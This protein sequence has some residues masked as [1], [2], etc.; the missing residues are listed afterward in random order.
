M[1]RRLYV[2]IDLGITSRHEAA[3]YDP[4]TR[5]FVVKSHKFTQGIR[6]YRS[7]MK[8]IKNIADKNTEII[9]CTEPTSTS[10][11]P[12]C[13][14]LVAKRYRVYRV[15][16]QKASDLRKF[17]KRHHKSNNIDA[18]TLAKIA[19]VDDD[20]YPVY[21]P[22]MDIFSLQR[23]CREMDRIECDIS[24]I[25]NRLHT[26]VHFA[27]PELLCCFGKN[28]FTR[29]AR[30]VCRKYIDPHKIVSLGVKRLATF[31]ENHAHGEVDNNLAQK[32]YESALSAIAIYQDAETN[33]MMPV[34]YEVIK[35]ELNMEMDRLEYNEKM[36]KKAQEKV[37]SLYKELDPYGIL[38]TEPGFGDRVA[39]VVLAFGGDVDRFGNIRKFKSFNGNVPRTKASGN[40]EKKGLPI[41]GAGCNMLKKYLHMA[42][43]SGRRWD[44]E[45]ARFHN[46]LIH[47]GLHHNQAV[48]ALA[49]RKA[50]VAYT[51]LKRKKA[52]ERGEITL[53]EAIYQFR[54][55]NGIDIPKEMAR[56]LVLQKF[57]SKRKKKERAI[58]LNQ[59]SLSHQKRDNSSHI[60]SPLHRGLYHKKS[61]MSRKNS[62]EDS[63]L[64]KPFPVIENGRV[65]SYADPPTHISAAMEDTVKKI[66]ARARIKQ[67]SALS[68]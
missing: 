65:I 33:G 9:F 32:I 57:P 39:P 53:G 26:M 54:D 58:K 7:L 55:L 27:N 50:G 10:W 56:R 25:K 23:Y 3:V 16:P 48:T 61:R 13:V 15:T 28:K 6:G 1:A 35:Y 19:L 47:R 62:T 4:E 2:G 41:T 40:K 11:I 14:F 34:D 49:N 59:G 24:R 31:L 45:D 5:N 38:K 60:K 66:T 43:E 18:K 67:H 46:R 20:V 8:R 42:A 22:E 44:V 17:Y 63:P 37:V 21:I 29:V 12:L 68:Q 36:A 64:W 51:L 30:A 52:Y